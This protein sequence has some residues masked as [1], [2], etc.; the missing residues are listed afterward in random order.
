MLSLLKVQQIS[1]V[2]KKQAASYKV[3]QRVQIWILFLNYGLVVGKTSIQWKRSRSWRTQTD[4]KISLLTSTR[5]TR[6]LGIDFRKFPIKTNKKN[7]SYQS[8]TLKTV[9]LSK[10]QFFGQ[11]NPRFWIFQRVP[12]LPHDR[13]HIGEDFR[14]FS[15]E[16]NDKN[17][18]Y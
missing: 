5:D 4:C 8:K 18:S 1:S 13:R 3:R 14:K 16:T 10:W 12:L 11:K 7:W 6:K 9:F 15:A 2:W 17:W